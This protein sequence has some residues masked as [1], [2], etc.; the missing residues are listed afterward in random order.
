MY[1]L[2]ASLVL[3]V[4]ALGPGTH[5]PP[6]AG[7][8]WM[9]S[10][11]SAFSAAQARDTIVF[12]AVNM[13]GERANDEAAK[14]LYND[15]LIVGLCAETVNIVA[16]RFEHSTS[17]SCPRF[18][19]LRC[20]DHQRIDKQARA[21]VLKPGPEGEVIAPHHVFLDKN[22]VI[23]L[24]VAYKVSAKELAWC[25]RAAQRKAYPDA[26]FA[27]VKGARAPRRLVMDGVVN[28]GA[29]GI[30]P[31]NEEEMEAAIKRLRN[32]KRFDQRIE[33]LYSLIATD[34][35]DAVDIITRD[36][37]NSNVAS[38]Y[39]GRGG[40]SRETEG[41][42]QQLLNSRAKLIH[43]I[44][45]YSPSSYWEAV[46]TQLQD[47]ETII[48]Q[49]A[50]VALEQLATEKAVKDLKSALKKEEDVDVR[51]C[52]V[53]AL[54]TCG[55]DSSSARKQLLTLA[56]SKKD[57]EARLNA[58]FAL[59]GQVDQKSVAKLLT[60]TLE[61]GTPKQMQAVVLGIAFAR[62]ASL[63]NLFLPL[64]AQRNNLDSGTLE[65]L[66]AARAVLSGENLSSIRNKVEAL[67]GDSLPREKLFGLSKN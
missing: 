55:V 52:L 56:K 43:R 33:D 57:E 54:G 21:I 20:E 63:Q 51:R 15:S 34:H 42:G 26:E 66:E 64:E 61:E 3:L 41:A 49:E 37:E 10:Y 22:G 48:R 31:L 65:A 19:S 53:R 67:F 46:V 17:G 6:E 9:E 14:K 12:L 1:K 16:S 7:I 39:V 29:S 58:L 45:V 11:D 30:H 62:N 38:A 5:A 24:S 28:M 18:G 44:G 40:A 25:F 50:A 2:F 4:P 8:A 13:D 27:K 23:L 32:T 60:S 47:T 59:G 35:P 36:L